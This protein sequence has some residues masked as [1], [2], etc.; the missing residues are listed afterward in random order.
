MAIE[1][2]KARAL[3]IKDCLPIEAIAARLGVGERTVQRWKAE[4]AEQDKD[5]DAARQAAHMAKENIE[6]STQLYLANFI[7]FQQGALAEVQANEQMTTTEKA[8]AVASLADSFAKTVK[9]SAITSP[10]INQL[11]I[12]IE[13][14]Q[15]LAAY[16]HDKHPE[17]APKLMEA[18]EPFALDVA[19][20]YV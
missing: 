10:Q 16:V 5:W 17:A 6:I 1:N 4:D 3:Y 8:Q 14:I 18:L 20:E 19:Q 2:Q 9:A 11:A 13:V 7:A 12:A 15:K